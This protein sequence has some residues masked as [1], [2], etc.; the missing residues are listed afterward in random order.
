MNRVKESGDMELYNRLD[1]TY[2]SDDEEYDGNDNSEVC[3][4]EV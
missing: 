4:G 2:L 1:S 3:L